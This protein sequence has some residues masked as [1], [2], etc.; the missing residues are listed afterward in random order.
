K[1]FMRA[2]DV[3]LA[4]FDGD[5]HLDVAASAWNGNQFAVFQN[6]GKPENGKEWARQVIDAK[7]AESRTIRAA[8]FNRD[9]K[10]DLLGTA[11]AA[12]RVVWYENPGKPFSQPWK[13]HVID[14]Q[15][16]RP[17][18]GI[19]VD[20]DRD[21][22]LDVVMALGMSAPAGTK[23]THEVVWYENVGR[24]GNGTKWT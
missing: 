7:A 9:G 3:A 24:P 6:S 11:S 4:D 15:S 2:Y 17:I 10:I 5:G 14:D 13:K 8:D 23:N 12:N 19:P 22:D 16:P 1:G 18:H 21:G 20:L